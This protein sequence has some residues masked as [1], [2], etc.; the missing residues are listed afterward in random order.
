MF[1]SDSVRKIIAGMKTMTRRVVEPQEGNSSTVNTLYGNVG[2]TLWVQGKWCGRQNEPINHPLRYLAD[3]PDNYNEAMAVDHAFGVYDWQPAT[4]MP[5]WACRLKLKIVDIRVERLQKITLPD[6]KEEG[7]ADVAEFIELWNSL[8][9][10][11]GY[12]WV[13]N[14]LVYV[15]KFQPIETKSVTDV[16]EELTAKTESNEI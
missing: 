1:S 5:F 16:I 13:K 9:A 6:A 15:I 7:V 2:D 3:Y 10:K 14:P 4:N 11:R 12:G 8:N